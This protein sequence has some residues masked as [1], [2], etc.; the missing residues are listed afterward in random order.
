[1]VAELKA[2]VAELDADRLDGQDALTLFGSY[3]VVERLC[4]SAKLALATRIDPRA[5]GSSPGTET[6]PL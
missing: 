1:M 4:C 6:L 3:V 2:A 5:S